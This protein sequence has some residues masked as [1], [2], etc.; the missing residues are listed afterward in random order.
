M[1]NYKQNAL[2]KI[3]KKKREEKMKIKKDFVD[4]GDADEIIKKVHEKGN[5]TI[6]ITDLPF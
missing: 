5:P 4:T 1:Y 3:M 6:D 2:Q